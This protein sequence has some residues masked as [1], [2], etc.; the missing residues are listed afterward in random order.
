M[1]NLFCS[2]WS[3]AKVWIFSLRETISKVIAGA[4][5]AI[6]L[7]FFFSKTQREKVSSPKACIFFQQHNSPPPYTPKYIRLWEVGKLGRGSSRQHI[8][9][10]WE[11]GREMTLLWAQ[12]LL[13]FFWTQK[14]NRFLT[15]KGQLIY[16][17]ILCSQGKKVWI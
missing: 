8:A 15:L 13:L 10:N 16:H 17:I 5:H 12:E 1:A 6:T 11:R 3:E 4:K 2:F 7:P 9:E 14:P